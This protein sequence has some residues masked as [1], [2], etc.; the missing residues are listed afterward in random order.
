MVFTAKDP[1]VLGVGYSATR[2][3]ISFL[4]HALADDNGTANP[5]A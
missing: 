5:I 3:V 2:D 1:L 4:H